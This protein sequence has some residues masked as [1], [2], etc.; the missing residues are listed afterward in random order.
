M[1]SRNYCF[2][3][4]HESECAIEDFGRSFQGIC[5]QTAHLKRIVC[6]IERGESSGRLHIQGY[7]ELTSPVRI[8]AIKNWSSSPLWAYGHYECRRGTVEQAYAYC[9][10]ENSRVSGPYEFGDWTRLNQQGRRNDLESVAKRLRTGV[11][12]DT[13]AQEFPVE[14]IRF[15]GG[16]RNL[17]EHMQTV[18]QFEL[19][20]RDW[21]SRL[22]DILEGPVHHRAIYWIYESQG[23][24]GK[25][26]FCKYAVARWKAYYST[27][28]KH[29]RLLYSF[30][31]EP[32][33][34]FDF[35]RDMQT[36]QEEEVGT[37]ARIDRVPYP[38]LE[39]IKN[40]Q[41][42]SGGMYGC[43]QRIFSPPHLV[44]FANYRPDVSKLSRDRWR[45]YRI[46]GQY[47]LEYE[48]VENVEEQ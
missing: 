24:T 36:S 23:N 48:S 34:L 41:V 20:P 2:T 44:C 16:I 26:Y 6:Q 9:R 13:V 22:I 42:G 10:K 15:S 12:L 32:I 40:G 5:E 47:S 35:C 3:I 29:D 18:S 7:L 46:D 1:T 4:N 25:S 45:I 38:V 30:K 28:G 11:S 8:V 33:V 17:W 43:G 21:Q 27:G 14:F 39:S 19:V 37:S 31:G